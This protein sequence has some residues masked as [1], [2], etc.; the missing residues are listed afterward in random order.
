MPVEEIVGVLTGLAR[1]P[2]PPHVLVQ[3]RDYATRFGLVTIERCPAAL[4]PADANAHAPANEWLL[5]HIRGETLALE[6]QYGRDT[7]VLLGEPVAPQQ[8]VVHTRNRGPLKRALVRAGYPADDVAG[9]TEGS[10]IAVALR[11]STVHGEPFVLREYQRVAAQTFH[12]GGSARGGSGVITLPCGAGKTVVAMAVMAEVQRHTLVLTTGVSA[13]RQWVRELLDKTSLTEAEIGEFDGAE[14]AVRPVTV[15]TYQMLTHRPAADGPFPHMA[16]FDAAD[17]GLI[18]YDE[19]HVLP[20]PIFQMTASL[21][22]RR[23]LGLTATL[24]REDGCED[25][26]F[27]LIGPRKADVPWKVLERQGWI[28][29]AIC[30]EVRVP[31]PAERTMPYAI[32]DARARFRV[33][34]ESEAKT[35]IV[36][37]LLAEH[38]GEPALVIGTYVEQLQ[39]LARALDAPCITGSTPQRRRDALFAAFRDGHL[40]VL[41]VSKVANFAIDLP[42]AALAIQVSG[43]FGSRQEEAQRLGRILRPKRGANQAHFY[44]IVSAD[45]VEQEFSLKRQL[46]LCEQG[47]EYHI[48]EA[49]SPSLRPRHLRLERSS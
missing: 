25:D 29:K 11:T 14:R 38:V 37:R 30:A 26:V 16:L 12:D 1:F 48:R 21:Q 39:E 23:R 6:L 31:L 49:A 17:W 41:V 35:P 20:A 5:V 9:Y 4:L 22:A 3:V 34:S 32:A 18:V 47:Y 43:T 2:V 44:S 24:V 28:A 36:R 19:V 27:A 8:Y 42:D 15:A 40:P 33:A 13:A 10:P 45:T 7:G 46:F